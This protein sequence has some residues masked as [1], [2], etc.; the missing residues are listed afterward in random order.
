MGRTGAK[1]PNFCLSR[2]TTHFRVRSPLVQS[3]PASK[4]IINANE[5]SVLVD[6]SDEKTI[7]GVN[8]A[9]MGNETSS[10]VQI[11]RRVMIVVDSSLEAKGAIQWALS[12]T[13]QNQDTIVLLYVTKPTSS[14]SNHGEQTNT[15]MYAKEYELL[16]SLKNMCH[17][18][19]PKV[20][21]EVAVVEGKEKGPTIVAEAKNQGVSLLILGQKKRSMT[22]RLVMM[23]AG[24]RIGAGVVEYCIDNAS[25]MTIGVRRNNRKVGGYLITT[26]RHK[27][28]W[29]LA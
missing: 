17:V 7:P 5:D 4:S 18:K 22:W 20:Q 11:G 29:L 28:F 3:K 9:E 10:S 27:D 26:K 1:S 13:I 8:G 19:R 16:Y 15:E 14:T 25:C 24:S 6:N 2:V 12:H 21:I 23:W